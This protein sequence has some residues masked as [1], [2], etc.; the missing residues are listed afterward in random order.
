MT[1]EAHNVFSSMPFGI[2]DRTN[3][4]FLVHLKH[5]RYNYL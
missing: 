3:E 1:Y 4:Y 2:H 5:V